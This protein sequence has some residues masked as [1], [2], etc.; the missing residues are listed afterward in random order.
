MPHPAFRK[1]TAVVLVTVASLSGLTTRGQTTAQP[2]NQL[3]PA[4]VA[5]PAKTE[6]KK[7]EPLELEK[8]E[9]TGSRLRTLGQEATAIAVYSIDH[10]ELERRGVTRLADI[11]WA[12]PQLGG[13]TGFNDNLVNGG[14]SR[15]QMVSTSF[16]LRGL[17][18]NST[19]VLVDGRRVPHTGQEAP[20]GAGG[21][22]DFSVDG[23]P[24]SA[25]ERIDV[26]PQG[27]G[28]VYGSEAIAGVINIVL[29]KNYTGAELNMTYDNTFDTD[30]GQKT[31][32]LT[33]GRRLG[34]L[35][36]FLTA[37]FEDQNGLA[38]RDRWFT[39]TS[40]A[41]VYGSTSTSF[42]SN[43]ASGAGSFASTTA[44]LPANTGQALLPGTATNIVGIPVGSNG[45]T[46]A[47]AAFTTA[48][49]APFDSAQYSNGIDSARRK[50][51]V[52]KT[53]YEFSRL[54]KVY[55]EGRYSEFENSFIS[56]PITLSQ[57]L[58]AGYP[59]N[60]FAGSVYLR[61]VFYDLPPPE[62]V[63]KQK[64]MGLTAGLRGDFL[65]TWRYDASAAWARNVVSDDQV[66]GGAFNLTLL[67][68]AIA[69]T[70]KPLLAYDSFTTSDPNAP[71][72]LAAL[73]P[74]SDHKDTT[75]TYQYTAVADGSVWT[76]WAGD[77]RTALGVEANE[78]KVKFWREPSIITPTYTLTK[79][80]ERTSTAA[81]GEITIPLLSD[82][83]R[84]PLVHRLEVGGAIRAE[85]YS[86]AGG[87]TS[88]TYRALFQPV[89]WL[90]LRATRSEGFKPVRLYDLL[91][92]VTSFNNTYTTT[93]N[94]RDPLRGNEFVTGSFTYI[95]GGNPTLKPEESVSRTAGL[96][97]DV[98][99]Q[100]FKGLSFSV[101]YYELEYTDRSGSTGL[102]ILMTYFPERVTRA[103]RTPADIAAG[104]EGLVTTWDASNINL[105][106][107]NT[108]GIDYRMSYNRN[109]SFGELSLNAAMSDPNVTY[110][111]ATPAAVPTSTFGH[112]PRKA[113]GSVFLRRGPWD[114]GISV[115]YQAPY[116]ISG[117]SATAVPRPA[118]IEFNPQ[119]S[120][121]FS[122]V[123]GFSQDSAKW[124]ARWLSGSKFT[125]T[126]INALNRD[127]DAL[128][129]I[130]GGMVMDPR[131]RRYILSLTKKF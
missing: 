62:T 127:P 14:V 69:S 87:I 30:V 100:L 117:F 118:Y 114:G 101:D 108:R 93:S 60:P 28:A 124:W 25:I 65:T 82:Q 120:Y 16:N 53:D 52:L 84:I 130:N 27:A 59:G 99:G 51:I 131:L 61:K 107:V 79:P 116:Y 97:L 42:L 20:G 3:K 46:A 45:S 98:P 91:A 55:L 38:S 78:E 76:G 39:A 10:I 22:E 95:S 112:Q 123:P 9:V 41:R 72:V 92:P 66:V 18:G 115:N 8:V 89:K 37:S 21:R 2:A 113:S 24:V 23:I 19:L 43:V 102:Q 26:L 54:A 86:D 80:F 36:T 48:Y 47:N 40:D 128:H 83:Q 94:I 31:I 90:T 121:N 111:K 44:P 70:N 81:F 103:A 122:R 35:T 129:S 119:L 77:V 63:S 71:G 73:R 126:V 58:P 6:A 56:P 85:D 12:I 109:F 104:Y 75:D 88:P 32:S 5:A 125:V 64:N 7:G 33:A 17:G 1:L 11:R 96:V 4:D 110:T 74:T 50:S 57:L 105:A 68:A 67:N 29:K 34:K 15:A 49:G 106:G 13:S